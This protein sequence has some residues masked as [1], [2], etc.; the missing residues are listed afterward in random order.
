MP[1]WTQES[2]P[3]LPT[4]GGLR[5]LRDWVGLRPGCMSLAIV[6]HHLLEP[7]DLDNQYPLVSILGSHR[8][9]LSCLAQCPSFHWDKKQVPKGP[10][11]LPAP[12]WPA[13]N[14]EAE[15]MAERFFP[16]TQPCQGS[17]GG[18]VLGLSCEPGLEPLEACPDVP[19]SRCGGATWSPGKPGGRKC[20]P[21]LWG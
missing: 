18:P 16:P 17:A 20:V 14:P 15:Q 19:P 8:P 9:P 7:H 4:S 10:D 13:G 21:C 11:G 3:Q 5:S 2:A 1:N 6:W 12:P